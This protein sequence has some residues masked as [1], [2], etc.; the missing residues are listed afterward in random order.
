MSSDEEAASLG[1]TL[2]EYR[3]A[4]TRR[5]AIEEEMR[6]AALRFQSLAGILD[7][8]PTPFPAHQFQD[9]PDPAAVRALAEEFDLV[10][11]RCST[12]REAL[13]TAGVEE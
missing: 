13:R 10:R 5:V 4:K 1:R 6:R 7:R 8:K 2:I 3:E 9:M 12:L 11:G